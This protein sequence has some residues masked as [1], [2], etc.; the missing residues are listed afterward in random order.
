[1]ISLTEPLDDEL[2]MTPKAFVFLHGGREYQAAVSKTNKRELERYAFE[3]AHGCAMLADP[4][5]TILAQALHEGAR[6]SWQERQRFREEKKKRQ[7]E[8]AEEAVAARRAKP[9]RW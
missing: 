1:M 4:C 9:T 7:A 8:L 5:S 2:T 3:G 6:E